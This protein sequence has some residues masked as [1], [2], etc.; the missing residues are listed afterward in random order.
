[1]KLDV[2]H[3]A[4]EINVSFDDVIFHS[5]QEVAKRYNFTE[6]NVPSILNHLSDANWVDIFGTS[7]ANTSVSLLY[8]KLEKSF[9]LFVTIFRFPARP[10]THLCYTRELVNLENCKARAFKYCAEHKHIYSE[11]YASYMDAI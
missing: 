6:A 11:C 4:Y 5:T 2:H 7:D 3:W 9:E 10:I 8:E 1:L